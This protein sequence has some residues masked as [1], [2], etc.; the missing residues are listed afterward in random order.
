MDGLA[1]PGLASNWCSAAS[2]VRT[3]DGSHT[4]GPNHEPWPSFTFSLPTLSGCICTLVA[5]LLVGLRPA[6][7]LEFTSSGITGTGGASPRPVGGLRCGDGERKVL[8]V[9]EPV[10]GDLRRLFRR[11]SPDPVEDTEALRR[12]VRF[13]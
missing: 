12:S 4:A 13:V 1:L 8:S 9:I 10:L 5:L 7:A 2:E 11:P 3:F 6:A